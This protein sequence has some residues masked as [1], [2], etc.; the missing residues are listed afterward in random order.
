VTDRT[1]IQRKQEEAKERRQARE[2]QAEQE[3]QG[4]E[5]SPPPYEA[6]ETPLERLDL[7]LGYL[8]LVIGGGFVLNLLVIAVI[9]G[10]NGG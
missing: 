10:A 6:P 1:D 8:A 5:L 9:A 3:R 2:Q 4:T 7:G